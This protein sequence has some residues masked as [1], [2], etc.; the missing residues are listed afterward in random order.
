LAWAWGEFAEHP[1]LL[2]PPPP[3]KKKK[4]IGRGRGLEARGQVAAPLLRKTAESVG[5]RSEA[6]A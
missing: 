2:Q 5:A 1:P 6:W 4:K 3:L